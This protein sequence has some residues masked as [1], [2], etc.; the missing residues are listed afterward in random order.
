MHSYIHGVHIYIYIYIHAKDILIYIVIYSISFIAA[1]PP[2]IISTAPSWLRVPQRMN[3]GQ[4][5]YTGNWEFRVRIVGHMATHQSLMH[6][7]FSLQAMQCA[8]SSQCACFCYIRRDTH[9][10]YMGPILRKFQRI[11]ICF[12]T[13]YYNQHLSS[14]VNMTCTWKHDWLRDFCKMCASCLHHNRAGQKAGLSKTGVTC[15]AFYFLYGNYG[16]KV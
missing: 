3:Y 14:Q 12:N 4:V 5:R 6:S 2:C 13:T 9:K 1:T 8:I 10:S 15:E 16:L 7:K 11:T